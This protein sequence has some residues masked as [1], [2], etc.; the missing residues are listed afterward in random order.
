MSGDAGQGPEESNLEEQEFSEQTSQILANLNEVSNNL[1]ELEFQRE[2]IQIEE[3]Y[4]GH[5]GRLHDVLKTKDQ[6]IDKLKS[7]IEE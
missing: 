6:E 2:K 1:K 4:M 3:H 5:I 7:W